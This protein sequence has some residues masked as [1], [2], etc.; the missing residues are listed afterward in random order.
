MEFTKEKGRIKE[1]KSLFEEIM[2][3]ISPNVKRGLGT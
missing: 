1:A 2:A 3:E